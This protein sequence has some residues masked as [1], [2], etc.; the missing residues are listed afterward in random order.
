M[1]NKT[2]QEIWNVVET[3]AKSMVAQSGGNVRFNE[4]SKL[5]FIQYFEKYYE[6][7]KS[8]FMNIEV[9]DLDRHKVAAI[10]ICSV[11]EAN[12]VDIDYVY[13]AEN[14]IFLGNERIGYN[15]G[16][17]YMRKALIQFMQDTVE[18]DKFKDFIFPEALMCKTEFKTILCRNVWYEKKYYKLNPMSLATMLFLVENYSLSVSGV[19]LQVLKDKSMRLLENQKS[20]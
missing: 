1:N 14:V 13:D 3:E 18:A 19:D 12:V 8:K 7:I 9:V 2:I 5:F 11:A 15:V 16:L 6:D 17:D 10:I 4:N 20:I